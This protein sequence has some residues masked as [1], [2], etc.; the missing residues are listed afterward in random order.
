MVACQPIKSALV[1]TASGPSTLRLPGGNPALDFV[2]TAPG[3]P[4]AREVIASYDDLVE[5]AEHA[6]L[7][8]R[9]DGERLRREA[10]RDPAAA[11][12]VHERALAARDR[13]R[14]VFDDLRLGRSPSRSVLDALRA[15][16]AEAISHARLGRHGGRFDWTWSA[17]DDLNRA[18]WPVVHAA[19]ELLR[20][21]PLDRLKSCPGCGYLFLDTTKNRSRRWCAMEDCGTAEKVRRIV[22]RRKASRS[23]P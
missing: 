10:R 3:A 16:A 5:W 9:G 12:D 6:G 23:A 8:S 11:R 17:A 19:V 20:S 21:G 1:E 14:S 4:G 15:D 22:A 7:L 13:A 2:N 18:V